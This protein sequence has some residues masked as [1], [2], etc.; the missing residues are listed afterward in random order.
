MFFQINGKRQHVARA[1]A[2]LKKNRNGRR[3]RC[4]ARR[5]VILLVV[6]ALLTLFTLLG[7]T[8]VLVTSQSRLSALNSVR[9]QRSGTP[10]QQLLSRAFLDVARGSTEEHSPIQAHGLLEDLYGA[11]LFIGQVSATPTPLGSGQLLTVPYGTLSPLPSSS[12]PYLAPNTSYVFTGLVVT[13]RDGAAANRSARIVADRVPETLGSGLGGFTAYT[14]VT[15]PFGGAD[16]S[17]G[18]QATP[19]SGD[20]FVINGRP[21][22]GTGF[23]FQY[24]SF[25]TGNPIYTGYPGGPLT[26]ALDAADPTPYLTYLWPTLGA[27]AALSWSTPQY[28]W[29]YALLPNHAHFT[30]QNPLNLTAGVPNYALGGGYYTDP[31]G[32]GVM[33]YNSATGVYAV[34]PGSGAAAGGANE[35]YDAVDFQNMF[36]A[37]HY[38]DSNVLPSTLLTTLGT[39][40]PATLTHPATLTPVPSF[41]RPELIAYWAQQLPGSMGVASIGAYSAMSPAQAQLLAE[42]RRKVLLRPNPA[43]QVP[44]PSVPTGTSAAVPY[45][46]TLDL[47]AN[48]V[49][50]FRE[51]FTDLNGNGYW[52]ASVPPNSTPEPFLDLN[53]DLLYTPGDIDFTGKRFNPITGPYCIYHDPTTNL[54]MWVLENPN[55]NFPGPTGSWDVDND[56]DGLTDS[57]WLDLGYDPEPGPDGRLYKPLFAI[58]CVDMDGKLNLNAHGMTAHLDT[59]RYS[60]SVTGPFANGSGAASG[61]LTALNGASRNFTFGDGA[62]PAEVNLLPML[63]RLYTKTPPLVTNVPTAPINYSLEYYQALLQ[64]TYLQANGANASRYVNG[65]YGEVDDPNLSLAPSAASSPFSAASIIGGPQAGRTLQF[66]PLTTY[67]NDP[68]NQARQFLDRPFLLLNAALQPPNTPANSL[69]IFFDFIYPNFQITP[70]THVP[71]G[72]SNPYNLYGR[73]APLLDLRGQPYYA[74]T[75]FLPWNSAVLNPNT[76]LA[77]N[78]TVD[79]PY[80]LDLSLTPQ[81]NAMI[82]TAAGNVSQIDAPFKPE[83]LERVLRPNDVDAQALSSRL[84]DLIPL[85]VTAP[86]QPNQLSLS[87]PERRHAITTNSNDLP[88]PG[89]TAVDVQQLSDLTTS[90]YHQTI[91]NTTPT[92]LGGKSIVD[93]ARARILA[94]N[95]TW[96]AATAAQPNRLQYADLALFG[97]MM[98]GEG[99]NSVQPLLAPELVEGM[100]IDINRP[101]GNGI[102]DNGNG[103]VDEPYEVSAPTEALAFPLANGAS[104]AISLD[105][106]NDG[107]LPGTDPTFYSDARARQLMA[108]HL[109]VTMMLLID[110]LNLQVQIFESSSQSPSFTNYSALTTTSSGTI[111]SQQ[112]A[113]LVAQWAINVVDFRDADSIMT[114]FEFDL[115][116]FTDDDGNPLNGTW[117]VN[118]IVTPFAGPGGFDPWTMQT[119]PGTYSDTETVAWRGVVWGCERPELL[120]TETMAIHDRGT[121]DTNQATALAGGS[122]D[123]YVNVGGPPS[124]TTYDQVRRP[125]GSIIVELFNP[126]SPLSAPQGDMLQGT[127]SPVPSTG[128]V[129]LTQVAF[130]PASP[131]VVSPVWRLAVTYSPAGYDAYAGAPGGM[132]PLDPR[133]PTLPATYIHRVAYFAPIIPGTTALGVTEVPLARSFFADPTLVT[134]PVIVQP[135]SY[136]LVA[137]GV[138]DPRP[139]SAMT[140][141]AALYFGGRN[142]TS[143]ST[144]GPNGKQNLYH[145]YLELNP[146]GP[147]AVGMYANFGAGAAGGPGGAVLPFVATVPQ[148]NIKN[149][150]GLPL[151]TLYLNGPAVQVASQLPPTTANSVRFSLSEPEAGYPQMPTLIGTTTA[152]NNPSTWD[153]GFYYLTGGAAAGQYPNTPFDYPGNPS[154]PTPNPNVSPDGT[155]LN[156]TTI[157]LQRLA[158]PMAPWDA[159][160]NPYIIV[161]SMPLDLTSYTGENVT[162][163]AMSVTPQEPAYGSAV[164]TVAGMGFDARSRGQIPGASGTLANGAT[165]TPNIWTTASTT[166]L[167]WS[168][169]S[170]PGGPASVAPLASLPLQYTT[171]GFLNQTYWLTSAG[172]PAGNTSNT[173]LATNWYAG[174]YSPLV[175]DVNAQA[176]L[177]SAASQVSYGGVNMSPT[178]YYG[179]PILP[180]PWLVWNNRPFISQ[181][182]LMLV[183]SSSPASLVGDFGLLGYAHTNYYNSTSLTNVDQWTPYTT[184]YSP[185]NPVAGVEPIS[186]TGTSATLA[187]PLGPFQHLLNFYD[188]T[189][190]NATIGTTRTDTNVAN[191][192]NFFRIFEY[193]NSPSPYS[194]TQ[195][196]LN[197]AAMS[198]VV[199]GLH[200]FHPPF[201]WQSQYRD[202]GRINLNTVFDPIVFQGLMDDYPQWQY[203]AGSPATSWQLLWQGLVDTRRGYSVAGYTTATS[204]TAYQ[205]PGTAGSTMLPN[206]TLFNLAAPAALPMFPTYF[207]NPFRPEGAGLLE[208]PVRNTNSPNLLYQTMTM[209]QP[210]GQSINTTMLRAASSAAYPGTQATGTTP[211]PLFGATTFDQ[212]N[213]AATYTSNTGTAPWRQ[214]ARNAY[215]QY[216]AQQRLGNLV[217]NRSNVYGIWITVGYFEALPV[218]PSSANPDGYQLGQ[219]KG[220]DTGTTDRHRAFFMFDRSIPMGFQRGEDLNVENGMLVERMIE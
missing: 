40:W 168:T 201:N 24:A 210:A 125:R 1:V 152:A 68:L 74:G 81:Q 105:L 109:Y 48:G 54:E 136:A 92:T 95:P 4:H 197:P 179:D 64:G 165:D 185:Y 22:S 38:F 187:V 15:T 17:D 70:Y 5:G 202:P 167:N 65:R 163:P 175:S 150:V 157:Y 59:L 84:N 171:F 140:G 3:S 147:T 162:P 132:L 103:A 212:A 155:I 142:S 191:P 124:D 180:F 35:P 126:N 36:L 129:N 186:S 174:F 76:N 80:E 32:P 6:M 149:V 207:A 145:N 190:T 217:T 75:T 128:G 21:F 8:L 141:I 2:A 116:P 170:G 108:R 60:G 82:V 218:L 112:L 110:D 27:T 97:S 192:A 101:V 29:P 177:A 184:G 196:L 131:S 127:T 123:T 37:M 11:P 52:D 39:P 120:L 20:T 51:P 220:S 66:D 107:F 7:L 193:L 34:A 188:S 16:S 61:S 206:L 58:L 166:P 159:Y 77:I 86:L 203:G 114:P 154:V 158:N 25:A 57:I 198:G 85:N 172:A 67:V 216:Q 143:D 169:K 151:A 28:L 87:R 178:Q 211:V 183:P 148:Q 10:P 214:A 45:P 139:G 146:F 98:L 33:T 122:S 94:R 83:E 100:R 91:Y 93:M 199:S 104:V 133:V 117:D 219:E 30:P 121:A 41:H 144:V 189:I 14:L 26:Y 115:D 56:N 69:G 71:S 153:D 113:Y 161:D 195:N 78:D 164:A 173:T 181:Y 88:V 49:Y 135:N 42:L 209:Q 46:P 204:L 18:G 99:N 118:D 55:P 176:R 47:N 119:L 111:P 12:P 200:W 134:A 79:D 13:M 137:P 205:T 44:G 215:F 50:D 182:E 53:G 31:G 62:G 138:V 19:Q 63:G 90:A 89:V 130:N 9:S 73:G 156:Y 102:D 160:A 213:Q 23:G 43:D 96:P 208:P 106:N 194:G 72:S